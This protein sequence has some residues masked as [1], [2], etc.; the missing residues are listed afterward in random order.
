MKRW[1][2]RKGAA[3]VVVGFLAAGS[4][5]GGS[6]QDSERVAMGPLASVSVLDTPLMDV[7]DQPDPMHA[8]LFRTTDLRTQIG[9]GGR[10]DI[11]TDPADRGEAER[12]RESF[13]EPETE[14]FVPGTWNAV[15]RYSRYQGTAWYRRAFQLP[16]EGTI[17][18]YSRP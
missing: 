13:P 16:T 12:Y 10:W 9:L 18:L 11:V 6:P 2:D 3:V 8:R 7:R 4:S 15:D 17:R 14:L 5:L 1:M